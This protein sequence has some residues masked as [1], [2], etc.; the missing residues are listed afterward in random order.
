M[1]LNTPSVPVVSPPDVASIVTVPSRPPVIVVVATPLAAVSLP[2]PVTVPV[3]DCLLKATTV[4]LSEVTVLP[5]ASLIVAVKTRVAP[6]ERSAV[7][8]V[9]AIWAAAPWTTLNAPSVPRVKPP[10]VAS[11]VTEP[12]RTPV[13][14]L[15]ATP[16]TAV[17]LPAPLTVPAPDCLA[18]LTTVVLSEVTVLPAASWTVAVRTRV[19]AG[20]EVGGCAGERD[21]GARAVDDREGAEDTGRQPARGG[22]HRHGADEPA[23]DRLGRDAAGGGGVAGAGDGARRRTAC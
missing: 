5:A 16:A 6:A 22:F 7:D 19:R 20:G 17:S 3:P 15:V 13:T 21:L 23:G 12:A 2:V 11:I 9:N 14:V 18:K 8:P 4:V 1:T 10:A